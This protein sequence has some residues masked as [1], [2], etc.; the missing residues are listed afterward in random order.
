MTDKSG[1]SGD[2][3]H[4]DGGARA[5]GPLVAAPPHRATC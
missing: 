3:V 5:A 1:G 4:G 2:D